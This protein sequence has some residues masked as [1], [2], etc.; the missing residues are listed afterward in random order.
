[1]REE[2]YTAWEFI[3]PRKSSSI[4][5]A[6]RQPQPNVEQ[7]RSQPRPVRQS[8]KEQPEATPPRSE[9]TGEP[10]EVIV[11]GTEGENEIKERFFAGWNAFLNEFGLGSISSLLGFESTP[12]TPEEVEADFDDVDGKRKFEYFPLNVANSQKNAKIWPLPTKK[13]MA[14]TPMMENLPVQRPLEIRDLQ[15]VKPLP[16]KHKS[17]EMT[18]LTRIKL[19]TAL[20]PMLSH[21][22]TRLVPIELDDLFSESRVPISTGSLKR[23]RQTPTSSIVSLARASRLPLFVACLYSIAPS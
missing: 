19:N 20:S 8:K 1:M 22:S 23:R 18:K 3:K 13:N 2:D 5:T 21:S 11:K 14:A 6:V 7:S 12:L 9:F 17:C 15:P 4:D 16:K 10:T